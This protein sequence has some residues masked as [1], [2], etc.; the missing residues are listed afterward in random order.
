MKGVIIW[1]LATC[2]YHE[3]PYHVSVCD[4]EY[5]AEQK[6]LQITHHI[7]LDDFEETLIEIS[8]KPLDIINP[9]RRLERDKL[10]QDYVMSHFEIQVNGKIVEGIYLGHELEDDAI[11]IY[12]EIQG[13]KKI[14][15]IKVTNTI[16]MTKFE[17]QVN[18]VHINYRNKI[19]SMKL[20]RHQISDALTYE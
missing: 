15:E 14:K 19:R 16:L 9:K 2:T 20:T 3:H 12:I 8:G 13:V 7:F 5:K 4:V 11:F 18:L 1:L 10:I 17:D 6:V